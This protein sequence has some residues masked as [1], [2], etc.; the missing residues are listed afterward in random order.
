MNINKIH[1]PGLFKEM[2]DAAIEY[3]K[4][5]F[6]QKVFRIWI[7]CLKSG[8]LVLADKIVKKYKKELTEPI[9]FDRS[10]AMQYSLF[11]NNLFPNDK[12]ETP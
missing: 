1:L 12:K 9:R 3:E 10:I 8:R 2:E 4:V 7:K 5:L 6:R 11:V